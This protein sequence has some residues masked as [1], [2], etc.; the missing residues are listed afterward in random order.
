MISPKLSVIIFFGYNTTN[1]HIISW[2]TNQGHKKEIKNIA[3]YNYIS[4]KTYG[5]EDHILSHFTT[6]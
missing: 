4:R 2:I 3:Y 1:F 6:R 5:A